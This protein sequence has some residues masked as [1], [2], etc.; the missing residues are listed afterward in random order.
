MRHVN[1]NLPKSERVP[2]SAE[3]GKTEWVD[4][5]GRWAQVY[6]GPSAFSPGGA[7]EQHGLLLYVDEVPEHDPDLDVLVRGDIGDDGKRE[8]TVT[9]RPLDEVRSRLVHRVAQ[10]RWETEESGVEFNGTRIST[11]ERAVNKLT[12]TRALAQE[13]EAATG[14]PWSTDWKTADGTWISVDLPTLVQIGLLIGDFHQKCYARE[15][16]LI[17]AIQGASDRASLQA[18]IQDIE[19]FALPE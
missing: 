13:Y 9:P 2:F 7:A 10:R 12:Q 17:T 8:Y 18:V 4:L 11:T 5:N 3:N 6:F 1:T 14:N 19:V 16:E 15:K